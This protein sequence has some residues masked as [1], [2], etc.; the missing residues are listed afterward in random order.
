MAK[1]KLDRTQDLL[2]ASGAGGQEKNRPDETQFPF[3]GDI[4]FILDETSKNVARLNN[5][6]DILEGK[7]EN[8][9]GVTPYQVIY[10]K[11]RFR[12]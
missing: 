11:N 8:K 9:R 4:Q 6:M 12:V 5:G 3:G 2:N 1:E 10:Q 7:Y